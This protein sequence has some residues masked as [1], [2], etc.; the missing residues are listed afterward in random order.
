MIFQRS[1]RW[2]ALAFAPLAAASASAQEAPPAE[3][4]P[5]DI[6]WPSEH[7]LLDIRWDSPAVRVLL[8]TSPGTC[9]AS[10]SADT[11]PTDEGK[12]T[13]SGNP[14]L[15]RAMLYLAFD[16]YNM[17]L[18]HSFV[19]RDDVEVDFSAIRDTSQIRAPTTPA[20]PIPHG[21]GL[22]FPSEGVVLK[23]ARPAQSLLGLDGS[24]AT[25][26]WFRHTVTDPFDLTMVADTL[27][28]LPLAELVWGGRERKRSYSVRVPETSLYSIGQDRVA[29]DDDTYSVGVLHM[30]RWA[31]PGIVPGPG[32]HSRRVTYDSHSVEGGQQAVQVRPALRIGGPLYPKAMDVGMPLLCATWAAERER[33]AKGEAT[34]I[35]REIARVIALA[36]IRREIDDGLFVIAPEGY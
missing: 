21:E 20:K 12:W 29:G 35:D 3:Q 13:H 16:Q 27:D 18:M 25:Y 23:P 28:Y 8:G 7:P 2:L 36:R 5:L 34:A 24:W 6:Q 19:L 32:A 33:A 14:S 11:A 4:P 26:L 1:C 10:P 17:G 30:R 15:L 22:A 9:Q 31:Y